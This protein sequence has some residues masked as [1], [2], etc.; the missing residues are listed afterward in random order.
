VTVAPSRTGTVGDAVLGVQPSAVHEP[1]TLAEAAELVGSATREGRR[2]LFVGGGTELELGPAPHALDAILRTTGLARVLD[3][4]PSDQVVTAEAGVTLAALQ[5]SV[6]RNGQ[7]L[8]LDP[9]LAARAT[10]GGIVAANAFGPRRARFGSVRDLIIGIRIVRADGVVAKGGGKVVKTVAGFDLPKLMVGSLGTLGLIADV[11]F[12]LHPLPEE[13]VT[14]LVPDRKASEVWNF[15]GKMRQAQLEPASLVAQ[16]RPGGLFEIAVRFEGFGPGVKEQSAKLQALVTAELHCACDA[17][18]ATAASSFWER[19]DSLRIGSPVSVKLAAL[20]GQLE[21]IGSDVV[22]LLEG[23]LDKLGF[24]WYATLGLG[25]VSGHAIATDPEKSAGAVSSARAA[26]ERLGGSLVLQ[27]APP[28]VRE[29]V[30]V[31]GT[32]PPA[33]ALMKS[34]K[35]RMD[36]GRCLAPG[37]FVGGI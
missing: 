37:R 9:P 28:F 2:L 16:W 26:L 30:P 32:P 36:P 33:L 5:E 27:A 25:F 13:S 18:P 14:L 15:V 4:A 20:P 11:T 34:L 19:H 7:R 8:A 6:A 35:Q 17:L 24:A 10:L 3:Y 1:G 21:A 22:P 23:G 31:W 12:R 29:R